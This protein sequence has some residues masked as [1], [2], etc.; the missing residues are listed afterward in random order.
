MIGNKEGCHA[1]ASLRAWACSFESEIPLFKFEVFRKYTRKAV[2][3]ADGNCLMYAGIAC[4]TSHNINT[5]E[6]IVREVEISR[7][8][9]ADGVIFFTGASMVDYGYAEALKSTVFAD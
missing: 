4:R 5:F 6:G 9:G 1:Q 2:E 7:E 8:E 3:I